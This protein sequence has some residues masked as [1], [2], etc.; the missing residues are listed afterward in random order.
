VTTLPDNLKID[1]EEIYDQL[2]SLIENSQGRLAPII[3]ACDDINLRQQ[4]IQRYESE[5]WEAQIRV[6]GQDPSLRSKLESLKQQEPHL[7][8]GGKAVFTVTGAELLLRVT[9]KP[10]EEQ[11]ELDK[12]FG[13]LQWTREG[14]R[15]FRYPIVLWVI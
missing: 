14:L 11:S 7:Q 2:I 1:N 12:F 5:A 3:V 13:Y 8:R 9:L 4:I 6:L 15:E 10:E